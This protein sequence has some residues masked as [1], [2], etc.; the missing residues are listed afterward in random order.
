MDSSPSPQ[1]Q[2]KT[3]YNFDLQVVMETV[4]KVFDSEQSKQFHFFSLIYYEKQT[5]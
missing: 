5:W 2:N 1:K 3:F 4:L